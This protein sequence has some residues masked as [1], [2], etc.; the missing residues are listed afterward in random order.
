MCVYAYTHIYNIYVC[1]FSHDIY[2]YICVFVYLNMYMCIYQYGCMS[3]HVYQYVFIF[4]HINIQY[5]YAQICRI[6]TPIMRA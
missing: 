6:R 3:N 5:A 4:T 1:K 2:Q